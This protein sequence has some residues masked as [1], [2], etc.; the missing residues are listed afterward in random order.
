M[1]GISLRW[2]RWTTKKV[3]NFFMEQVRDENIGAYGSL[4]KTGTR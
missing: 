4:R 3:Y 2:V 1:V